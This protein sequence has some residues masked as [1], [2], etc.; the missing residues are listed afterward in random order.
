MTEISPAETENPTGG[1]G[2]TIA[3]VLVGL[4][5]SKGAKQLKLDPAIY[6]ALQK[7]KVRTQTQT[8]K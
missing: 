3:Y 5:T 8:V 6:E 4:K 1:Y 7:E 2:K